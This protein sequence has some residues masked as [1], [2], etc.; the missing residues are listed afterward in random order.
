MR[1]IDAIF[2]ADRPLAGLPPAQRKARRDVLV[3]PLVD[4]FFAWVKAEHARPRERGLVA[5]ALGYAVRQEG[6]LRRFFDD[7]RLGLENQT[8]AP[9]LRPPTMGVH[10][11]RGWPNCH[12]TRVPGGG[13]SSAGQ[14][15]GAGA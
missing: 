8:S 3:R 6:P 5:S 4:A 12:P 14:R 10:P 7:G 15:S 1:R 9:A 11:E 13:P 2:A